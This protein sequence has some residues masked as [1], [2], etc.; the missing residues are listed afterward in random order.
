MKIIIAGAGE[1]GIHLAK[2]L[3]FESQEIT[4]IDLNQERLDY[5][6]SHLDLFAIKDDATSVSVL[7]DA[8]VKSC[9]LLITVTSSDTTNFMVAVLGKKLGA[10]RTIARLGNPEF[11]LKE[12]KE[13]LKQ[14][15][16]DEVISPEKLAA[17]EICNLISQS[18]FNATFDF[19]NGELHM[20]GTVLN[21]D[22]PVV[23][24][25]MEEV[26]KKYNDLPFIT[27]S[28]QRERNQETIVPR[29]DTVFKSRDQVYFITNNEG[30]EKLYTLV[31]KEKSEVKKV[32]I[33]GGSRVAL[34]AA[35]NL[36]DMNCQIKMIEKHK[37]RAFDLADTL[38]NVMV[39]HGDG[40]NVELLYEENINECDTFIA[41]TGD[42]ETNIMSC[43]VA[44]SRGVRKTIAL[45][46]NMDYLHLSQ[47]IGIDSLINK[48]FLAASQ[49]VRYVRKGEVL[50]LTNVNNSEAEV[51]E[52]EVRKR[53]K[54]NGRMLKDI[55]LPKESII[56]GIIRDKEGVLPTGD[57][58]IKE[59]DHVIVFCLPQAISKVEKLFK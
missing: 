42:S 32:M 1:V 22:S 17:N 11:L 51:M 40:R 2:L 14:L 50:A 49:I 48:K 20:M 27:I 25:T 9:D 59:K 38:P 53:S 16:I 36:S 55:N 5:A 46:E 21:E 24:L 3:S 26:S 29:G 45:V 18:N 13:D 6:E 19:D 52:F 31:G 37:D 30:Y 4:L 15:G 7:T 56:G 57:F 54:V 28:V 47:S 33:L 41:L 39:I 43:L 58:K 44:K 35:K 10:R 8:N 23:G 34:K 12:A